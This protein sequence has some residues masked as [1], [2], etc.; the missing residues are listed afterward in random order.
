MGFVFAV[1]IQMVV[2]EESFRGLSSAYRGCCQRYREGLLAIEMLASACA[3]M[4]LR[5]TSMTKSLLDVGQVTF[6]PYGNWL[7]RFATKGSDSCTRRRCFLSWENECRTRPRIHFVAMDCCCY[8]QFDYL[9]FCFICRMGDI[10]CLDRRS[11]AKEA[12]SPWFLLLALVTSSGRKYFHTRIEYLLSDNPNPHN[13][14]FGID[15]L[16]FLFVGQ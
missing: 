8:D 1:C 11:I 10:S 9:S 13:P 4:N 12:E 7:L 3:T 16:K 14:A 15:F 2:F 6:R 5:G